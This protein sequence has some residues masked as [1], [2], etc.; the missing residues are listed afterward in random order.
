MKKDFTRHQTYTH[1][2]KDCHK[3]LV[4]AAFTSAVLKY[5]EP[6]PAAMRKDVIDVTKC[7]KCSVITK[8]GFK[9]WCEFF[10]DVPVMFKPNENGEPSCGMLLFFEVHIN[11]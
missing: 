2:D 7:E 1:A 4:Q 9:Y 10:G 5:L 11:I 8:S 6:N 3:H